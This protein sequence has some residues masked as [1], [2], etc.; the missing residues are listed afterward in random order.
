MRELNIYGGNAW[1]IDFGRPGPIV[2]VVGGIHGDEKTG[3][4]VVRR[5]VAMGEQHLLD[6][7]AGRLWLIEA[8]PEA[9]AIAVR[10]IKRE[11]RLWDLNRMCIESILSSNA[12]VPEIMRVKALIKLLIRADIVLDLHAT[13]LETAEPFMMLQPRPDRRALELISCFNVSKIVYDPHFIFGCGEPVSLDEYISRMGKVGLCYETGWAQDT[14]RVSQVLDE[15]LDLL[16][17]LGMLR[18]HTSLPIIRP[19]QTLYELERAVILGES[20][21]RWYNGTG[22]HNLQ[23]FGSGETIGWHGDD[24]VVVSTDSMTVFPKAPDRWEVGKPVCYLAKKL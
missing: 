15:V 18:Q 14:S 9:I 8:N 17:F 21:F 3:V 16:R 4:Q 12:R 2:A 23:T 10:A 22:Y 13:T 7:R 5:M 11:G 19:Q 1:E 24:P 6:I 20:G